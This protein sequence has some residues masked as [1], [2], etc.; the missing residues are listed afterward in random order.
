ML[1]AAVA[2]LA[3]GMLGRRRNLCAGD[4]L[5]R[6]T[7]TQRPDLAFVILQLQVGIDEQLAAF[8]GAIEFLNHRRKCRWHSGD[9]R[10]AGDLGAGLQDRSFRRGRL[11]PVIENDF[12]AAFPQNS[13]GE[14]GQ[15]LRHFR[16]NPI[17]GLNDHAAMRFVAQA[18]VIPLDRVHEIVQ[19]GHHFNAREA[20]S[21]DD[22]CQE[23]AAQFRV[24]PRHPLPRERE[25]G[26]CAAPWHPQAS[27][28]ALRFLSC[29]A[30]RESW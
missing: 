4:G 21:S 26:D 28:T 15:R 22:E 6:G 30:C 2:G 1:M 24:R 10:L 11:Q 23:L 8:L 17:A 12:D 5:D 9:Q 29:R 20:A 13:L 7:V 25:S 16:Q 14:N 18:K 27:E 19:L 3:D